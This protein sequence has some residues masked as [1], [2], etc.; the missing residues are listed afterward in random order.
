MVSSK[1][2]T[3]FNNTCNKNRY[4]INLIGSSNNLVYSNIIQENDEY[5][6]SIDNGLSLYSE[7]NLI[8]GN[9]FI[10]NYDDSRWKSQAYDEG[11]NNKWYNPATLKGNYWSD[12]SSGKYAIDGY[13]DAKDPYPLKEEIREVSGEGLLFIIMPFLAF[14]AFRLKRFRKET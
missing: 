2:N 13:A 1:Q 10:S 14:T 7:D 8:Y 3:I 6:V 4:G 11:N 9:H 12:F 5:G